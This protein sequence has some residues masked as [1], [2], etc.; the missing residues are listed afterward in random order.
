MKNEDTFYLYHELIGK[1]AFYLGISFTDNL[2][3]DLFVLT[4]VNNGKVK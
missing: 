1:E 4:F 3:R 2:L